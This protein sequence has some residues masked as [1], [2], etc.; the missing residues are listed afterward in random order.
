[1]KNQSNHSELREK[2]LSDKNIRRAV[3]RRSHYWFFSIFLGHYIQYEV[4]PF[5]REMFELTEDIDHRLIVVMA[6]RGSGKSTI[7][8]LSQTLW[9][10][11]GEQRKKFVLIISK[12]QAQAR[13]HFQNIRDELRYNGLLARDLGPFEADESSWGLSSLVLPNMGARITVASREQSIR[14][15]RFWQHRP[16][17]IICDD[18][19][20][21]T[22]VQSKE[23]SDDTY[24][25]FISEVM[26]A[27]DGRAK[28]IVLGNLLG[29]NSL[30]LRLR[31]DI[32]SRK[33]HGVFRAYPL[34]DD[35]DAVLWP[36][37]YSTTDMIEELRGMISDDEIWKMEYIL[38]YM[39]EISLIRLAQMNDALR[40]GDEQS[41]RR[42]H[43]I[44]KYTIS[45]PIARSF[46]I[47]LA[48]QQGVES[49]SHPQLPEAV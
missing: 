3:V 5:Q 37:K 34:L 21:S 7:M 43:T 16:D 48:E 12:T 17:L 46:L 28:V 29:K 9:S 41:S 45:A 32:E 47:E 13:T 1:M 19:E 30:L 20:D 6:F 2:I 24:R 27:G 18:L 25:W 11:L 49:Y 26:P 31:D 40:R 33:T 23:S 44:G 39:P 42:P 35:N 22:S 14:G 15:I 8:N 36:G 10:I 38:K 4:A